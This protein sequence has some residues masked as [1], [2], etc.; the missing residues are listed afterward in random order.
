MATPEVSTA[1]FT[2]SYE[3]PALEDGRMAVRDL[4]PALLALGDLLH[5][6]ND[7][8]TPGAPPVNLDI[9]AFR[10]GSFEIHLDVVV[11][12]VVTLLSSTPAGAAANLVQFIGGAHGFFAAIK[13]LRGRRVRRQEETTPGTTRLWLDDGTTLETQSPVVVLLQRESARRQTREVLA[14]LQRDGIDDVKIIAPGEPEVTIQPGDAE[15]V[16]GTLDD[17]PL[18]DDEREMA[19]T[20]VAVSFEPGN[21]WRLNDGAR[22]FWASVD[23]HSFVQRVQ[24]SQESFR[25][26]DI[27]ICRI[28][29]RQWQTDDGLRADYAVTRVV[30]H[31]PGARNVPL[32]FD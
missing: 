12:S 29:V 27:L 3:G 21:K 30:Q 5:E 25:K 6:A 20:L 22:T 16:E 14:P 10:E 2:L 9:R 8:V 26:G 18:V 17:T 15:V 4:A 32:P 23:D 19:V 7:L 28:R 11:A 31:V 1:A 13:R 24:Q